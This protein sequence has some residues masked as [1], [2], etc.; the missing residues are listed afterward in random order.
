MLREFDEGLD[1]RI[2]NTR[3]G[4]PVWSD[5][6]AAAEKERPLHKH[7]ELTVA[8]RSTATQMRR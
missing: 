6:A 8:R 2:A 3:D 1:R 5:P 4:K 7:G